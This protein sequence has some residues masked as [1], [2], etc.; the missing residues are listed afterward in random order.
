MSIR[1]MRISIASTWAPTAPLLL[2]VGSLVTSPAD[3]ALGQMCPPTITDPAPLNTTAAFDSGSDLGPKVTTD[4]AGTW[5]ATW[6]FLD[7]SGGPLGADIDIL[8]ARSTDNGASWTDPEPLN[9]NAALDSATDLGASIAADGLGNWVAVWISNNDF[10]GTIGTD[11]DIL[12]ARST[13]DGATWSDP[14]PL[15]TNAASDTGLDFPARINTDGLGNWV[16]VWSS[17]E[18]L[19]G[20]IGYDRDILLARSTDNGETWTAPAPLNNDAAFDPR[21]D[22]HPQLATDAAGNWLVVWDAFDPAGAGPFGIDVD[23][24]FSYSTDNGLAWTDPLPLN[25]N[26]TSD[27]GYDEFPRLTTDGA[28]NWVVVWNSNENLG[29]A[30]GTDTD[31]LFSRST[32]NGANWSDP[33]ALN[34]DAAADSGVDHFAWITSDQAGNWMAVWVSSNVDLYGDIVL[35][36]STDNGATWTDPQS[37]NTNAVP[38]SAPNLT[39]DGL[40]HW[41]AVWDSRDDLDGL[42]GTDRDILLA[43]FRTGSNAPVMICHIPPGNPDNAHTITVSESAVPAHLAHGDTCGPCGAPHPPA[44]KS[45]AREASD[46]PSDLDSD[47]S[48]ASADLALLLGNW[49]PCADCDACP[50][51]LDNDCTVG[52]LDLAILLGNWG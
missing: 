42:I 44:S 41:V 5:V 8:F 11:F 25:S 40:G 36:R 3:L 24:F 1:K 13:N 20:T 37:L 9:T 43:R 22:E 48:V 23:V 14:E 6:M 46:R 45:S 16:A 18:D 15:N 35:A 7:S 10:D 50:A 21:S 52:A 47:G 2:L 32:D 27:T 31:I 39:T 12:F 38:D 19:G 33:A 26:A 28:G 29:G 30:I 49:G 4:G 34:T 17:S 51:D